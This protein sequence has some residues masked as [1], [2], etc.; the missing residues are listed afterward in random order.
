MDLSRLSDI[1]WN[2]LE[3]AYGEASDVPDLLRALAEGDD[4]ERSKALYELF[5]NI[6]HQGT[7]YPA[8]VAAIPFLSS[9]LESRDGDDEGVVMLLAG[10]AGGS[11]YL[12]VHA[13]HER[14]RRQ[15]EEMLAEKGKRLDIQL[16]NEAQ[17]VSAVRDLMQERLRLLVPF[18]VK[19]S[20]S[21]RQ[22]VAYALGQYLAQSSALLSQLEEAV[23]QESDK[24]VLLQLQESARALREGRRADFATD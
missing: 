24:S 21:T 23:E 8:T 12:E 18:L 4:D 15:W 10:I 22:E 20:P 6:I 19:G 7:V 3:H 14:G 2:S 13:R 17:Y 1:D 9:I 5:G 16:E 11:G